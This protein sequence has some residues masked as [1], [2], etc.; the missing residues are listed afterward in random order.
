MLECPAVGLVR[1]CICN[2]SREGLFVRTTPIAL[3]VSSPVTVLV[4]ESGAARGVHAVPAIVV[5]ANGDGAGLMAATDAVMDRDL[6]DQF[7]ANA[8]ASRYG[9]VAVNVELAPYRYTAGAR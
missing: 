7:C 9:A 2:V 1:A 4:P 6:S 3:D 5:W 8:A